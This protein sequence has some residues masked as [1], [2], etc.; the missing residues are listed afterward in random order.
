MKHPVFI[1][2]TWLKY[3]QILIIGLKQG[4]KRLLKGCSNTLVSGFQVE[5]RGISTINTGYFGQPSLF[6]YSV[7]PFFPV[8]SMII[9]IHAN[10]VIRINVRM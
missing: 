2:K 8:P 1:Y 4:L 10:S 5:T 7:P 6:S 3:T 9:H